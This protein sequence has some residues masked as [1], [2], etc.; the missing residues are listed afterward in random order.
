MKRS[1]KRLISCLIC[2]AMAIA[3]L[4]VAAFA[5]G[6]T[7]VYCQA[8]DGWTKC[9]AYWWGSSAQ[10][11]SWPGIAMSQDAN[12]IWS[13]DVPSDATGLIFN[14]GNGTQ[15]SD[16]TVPTDDKVMYVFS[17]TYWTTYGKVEVVTEYYVAGT[18]SL[19][20][21]DWQPGAA[22]NKMT[23][24]NGIYTITFT[25]V[26][27]GSHKFKVTNG[28]WDQSWGKDAGNDDYVL[29]LTEAVN[30][31]E[32]R[33]D[34]AV[35]SVDV[36][37]NGAG[38]E[39][40]P[41]VD[42]GVYFV[43]G[44]FNDWNAAAS[45]YEMVATG[46]GVYGYTMTL[47]AGDYELKVT[48]G[49][50]DQS[51]GAATVSGN[52]E[53]SVADNSSTVS[54]TFEFATQQISVDVTAPGSGDDSDVT[55]IG[56]GSANFATAEDAWASPDSYEFI[57]AA[58]G[59][60]TIEILDCDPGYYVELWVNGDWFKDYVG[61]SDNVIE[62]PVTAG[63]TYGMDIS[64][65]METAVGSDKV[66]G[67]VTYKITANVAA[68]EPGQGGEGSEEEG[69]TTEQNP[70][71]VPAF[72]ASIGAGQTVWFV[73]DNY[74]HMINDGVYSMM[75]QISSSVSYA[76]T[77]RGE[78]IP[79]DAEGFVSYEMNDMQMQGRY[80]FSV[81]NN[82]SV[83]AFFSIQ[84]MDRP[85]YTVS[86]YTLTLGDNVV[87]P[88]TG[89]VNTLYEFSP[90]QT[91]IYTFSISDG[92]ISNWNNLFNPQNLTGTGDTFLQWTCT[93]AG[94]S[95]AIGV[96]QTEEAIVT[97]A[98][99]GDYVPEQEV[100]EVIYENT[101]D[102]GYQ[103][104]ENPEL[105][106]IDVTDDQADVAV[107]DSQGFYR[108]GSKY[109]PLMV[110]DLNEFPINLA[111]AYINGQLRAYILDENGKVIEKYNYNEA[112][113]EYL[114]AG[115]VP[116]TEELATMLKRI[117]DHRDWWS[118]NGFVFNETAPA[119]EETAWMVACSYIKGSELEPGDDNT[120]NQGGN[121]QGGNSGNTGS[122]PTTKDISMA[123]AMIAVV[124]AGTC[125]VVLK[126]KEN[127]FVG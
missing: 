46:A 6:T 53:F 70:I 60:I 17:N 96:T 21:V 51:W 69:G 55:L 40:P 29:E 117:G 41:P 5:A 88:D 26:A 102:F 33:F 28:T 58:D 127:I 34:P 83:E 111:D 67:F 98:R 31:V 38:H 24:S 91:G 54:V 77:Y 109:G 120:G 84:V 50:W 22:Q 3:L 79:V 49:T 19:C 86:E 124:L 93:D 43:A 27:A 87:V 4:P 82:G 97:V 42:G 47:D 64:S 110:A 105:V 2:L 65:G 113:N 108:Y 1:T 80:V 44:S 7:T 81:T 57:P 25:G 8:P 18:T 103:L 125:L 119:D 112:M 115:L 10:N 73:Y 99:I 122:N 107:L 118:A 56:E 39:A 95:V 48:N 85:A 23:E 75:L 30:T 106:A 89:F 78:N 61:T 76:V 121:N 100:E 13:Y 104:P 62:I 52:Y 126:K 36:V 32:I 92:M 90:E 114:E 66:A 15:T 20:G 63:T 94:Q 16:L 45:G 9:N 35:P 14:N 37:V 11:P 12:G 123:W 68:G 116:V 71:P 59:I 101:Y 74:D 72:G